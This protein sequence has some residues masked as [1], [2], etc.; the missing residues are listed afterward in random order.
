MRQNTDRCGKSVYRRIFTGSEITAFARAKG[1]S[2]S[3]LRTDSIEGRRR[4]AVPWPLAGK[5]IKNRNV[6]QMK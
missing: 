2:T 5:L 4:H 3:W 6:L 1:Q